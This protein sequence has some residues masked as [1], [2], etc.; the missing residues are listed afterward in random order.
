MSSNDND[1][2]KRPEWV[3][4]EGG[5][6]FTT[7]VMDGIDSASPKPSHGSPKRRDL[8]ID[9]HVEG[10]LASDRGIVARTITLVESN[11]PEHLDKAQE[12]LRRLLPNTGGSTRVGVTGVPGVGKSTFIEELGGRL[13]EAGK[14]VAVLAIDPSSTLTRGSIL[15]DK[16]RMERLARDDRCFI[17]PSPSSGTLGGVARKSRETMLVCEAAGFDVVLVETVG[18]GQSEVSVREMVDFFLLLMIPGAGDELQG[19][20][21]GVME[22]ADAL[23][24][25]KADGGN[26][27]RAASDRSEF[28]M[29]LHYLKPATEGWRPEVRTCSSATGDGID[30]IWEVV[31][32]F[33]D[34]TKK[35]GIF[36]RR[37]GDQVLGWLHGMV[38][39]QLKMRFF[40]N[41]EVKKRLPEI[42]RAVSRGE[43]PATAAVR[44]LLRIGGLE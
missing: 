30:E 31:E 12:V 27:T 39:E 36:E 15:G 22:L 32:R 28:E 8:S 10:V 13:L 14:R 38:E 3:P 37:R 11:A 1:D 16:T 42:E 25:N 17:R 5:E 34:E 29:A 21:R 43:V 18:V 20:K 7:S 2:R 40:S 19:I 23:L 33:V 4:K 6:G 9:D 26:E 41:G 44:E 35:S 24:I